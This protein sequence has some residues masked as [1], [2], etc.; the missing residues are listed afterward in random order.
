MAVVAVVAVGAGVV[1]AR[2][3]QRGDGDVIHLDQPGEYVDPVGH[4]P[5]AGRRPIM[6]AFRLTTADR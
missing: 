3:T 6:P 5:T 1:V 2:A 4:Q